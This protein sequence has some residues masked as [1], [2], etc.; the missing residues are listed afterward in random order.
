MIFIKFYS[1][2]L[3]NLDEIPLAP[4]FF[5][6]IGTLWLTKTSINNLLLKKDRQNFKQELISFRTAFLG[7]SEKDS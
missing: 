7:K 3:R 5:E 2:L 4:S 6:I 1:G